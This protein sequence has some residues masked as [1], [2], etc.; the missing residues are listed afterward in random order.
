MDLSY[1]RTGRARPHRRGA[2]VV[3]MVVSAVLSFMVARA[4][5]AHADPVTAS[6]VEAS[7]DF[8]VNRDMPCNDMAHL[9]NLGYE[10]VAAVNFAGKAVARPDAV[11]LV[12]AKAYVAENGDVHNISGHVFAGPANRGY[13]GG[14]IRGEMKVFDRATESSTR[15]KGAVNIWASDPVMG[16]WGTAHGSQITNNVTDLPLESHITVKIWGTLTDENF[17]TGSAPV[18]FKGSITCNITL[19]YAIGPAGIGQPPDSESVIA[20][21]D[22]D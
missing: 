7:Q 20:D 17:T 16:T 11:V 13:D 8:C 10:E 3:G 18:P 6:V 9:G 15:A 2:V 21:S 22:G 14:A 1:V 4:P 5:A 12:C 19:P